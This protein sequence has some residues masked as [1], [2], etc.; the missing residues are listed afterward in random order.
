MPNTT[1]RHVIPGSEKAAMP[2]AHPVRDAQSDERFEVTVRLRSKTPLTSLAKGGAHDDKLPAQREYL[3]REAFASLHGADAQDIAKI[4]AFAAAHQLVVV[5]TNSARR[6]VV[7]SG[8]TASMSK[9][10]GVTWSTARLNEPQLRQLK[11]RVALR[12]EL[13]ALDLRDTAAYIAARVRI[14]GGTADTV[15]TRDAVIAVHEHSRGIPRLTSVIC[16][17]ALV[18]GFASDVKPVGRDLIVEVCR[19]FELTQA[20]A[21]PPPA[22]EPAAAPSK[23]LPLFSAVGKPRRFSFF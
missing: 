10:F 7:L 19:D 11:Q 14:A 15:F 23:R 20:A 5:E 17:N 3:S 4:A 12:C 2:D 21:A 9:A 18:S 22:D 13:G 1:S 6:S 8:T 16:D